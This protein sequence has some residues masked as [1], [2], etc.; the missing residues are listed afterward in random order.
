MEAVDCIKSYKEKEKRIELQ[1]NIK[2]DIESIFN[3]VS[4]M[5]TNNEVFYKNF[6]PSFILLRTSYQ[7]RLEEFENL[8]MLYLNMINSSKI[9]SIGMVM[10]LLM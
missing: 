8:T 9:S 6:F 4:M 1:K 2:S 3:D 5:M 7:E 10:I